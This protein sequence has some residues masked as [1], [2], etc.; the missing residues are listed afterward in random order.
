MDCVMFSIPAQDCSKAKYGG[1]RKREERRL[2]EGCNSSLNMLLW[3]RGRGSAVKL[4]TM[5]NN[6]VFQP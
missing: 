3:Q 4:R 1:L 6:L 5:A 2:V